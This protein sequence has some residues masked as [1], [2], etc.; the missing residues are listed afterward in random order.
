[1]I[2]KCVAIRILANILHA[3]PVCFINK[4]VIVKRM[5]DVAPKKLS[6]PGCIS[7]LLFQDDSCF[8]RS[9]RS[10]KGHGK[11]IKFHEQISV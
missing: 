1:M 6:K 2:T 10:L 11:V 3:S 7:L 4:L 9:K 8:N 5:N